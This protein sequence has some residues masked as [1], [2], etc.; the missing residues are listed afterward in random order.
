MLPNYCSQDTVPNNDGY[1]ISMRQLYVLLRT[2]QAKVSGFD[3]K[4][5]SSSSSFRMSQNPVIAD[6]QESSSLVAHTQRSI[7]VC[8]YSIVKPPNAPSHGSVP[9]NT[10]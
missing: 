8:G 5:N 1:R 10:T 9:E 4:C 6:T 2:C 7:G 3:A